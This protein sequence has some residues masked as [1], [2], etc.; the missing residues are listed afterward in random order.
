V[1][2]E[3]K[4]STVNYFTRE[5]LPQVEF[6]LPDD[7]DDTVLLATSALKHASFQVENTVLSLLPL[8]ATEGG[9][10]STWYVQILADT[11]K[12]TDIDPYVNA[13]IL[14]FF[15]S[16]GINAHNTRT[17]V[18]TSIKEKA[19]SPYYPYFLYLLYVASKYTYKSNDSEMKEAIMS[20]ISNYNFNK[21]STTEKLFFCLVKQYCGLNLE[22]KEYDYIQS[23]IISDSEIPETTICFDFALRSK[24][25]VTKSSNYT[26][27]LLLE[28]A[29]FNYGTQDSNQKRQKRFTKFTQ[30]LDQ[31]RKYLPLQSK[32]FEENSFDTFSFSIEILGEILKIQKTKVKGS[33][34]ID[35]SL[36]LYLAW[37][38][39]TKIDHAVD[40]N[41]AQDKSGATIWIESLFIVLEKLNF[42]EATT[43]INNA[44][45]RA[46][47]H[48]SAK[49]SIKIYDLSTKSLES[50][51]SLDYIEQRMAPFTDTIIALA[52]ALNSISP[53]QTKSYSLLITNLF[54][55][56]QLNDDSHDWKEDLA[57]QT[58]T[59]ITT[60]LPKESTI[61][62]QELY[63]WEVLSSKIHTV[64]TSIYNETNLL[65]DSLESNKGYFRAKLKKYY[66]PFVKM[67]R[68]QRKVKRILAFYSK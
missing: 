66:S 45:E 9:P 49:E 57:S 40:T 2:H 27:A 17:F 39:F 63:F 47:H 18:L 6:K 5:F 10:Y 59:F 58:P 35:L 37:V 21:L 13:N 51:T 50:Y 46:N 36:C 26:K 30:R 55:L 16:I 22:D 3:F 12:W 32:D 7:V 43:V 41:T 34:V 11:K 62:E 48:Y 38:A 20:A 67:Q 56:N 64:S 23:L 8:E 42:S 44:F 4:N 28:F 33:T 60:Q 54:K 53:K 19:T 68:E 15:A 25:T 52:G 24:Q 31:Y 14:H 29:F 1:K 61:E 65:I